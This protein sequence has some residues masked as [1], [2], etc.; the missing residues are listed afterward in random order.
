MLSEGSDPASAQATIRTKFKKKKNY[1][2]LRNESILLFS[3][4]N[5]PLGGGGFLFPFHASRD[6]SVTRRA[7][8]LKK[9]DA[10]LF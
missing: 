4:T 8:R 2:E 1:H 6:V 3:L 5:E 9:E 10:I 7:N